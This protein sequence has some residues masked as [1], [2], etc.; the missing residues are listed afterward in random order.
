M[1][2][3]FGVIGRV[4]K[5]CKIKTVT[6]AKLIGALACTVDP[7]NEYAKHSTTVSR[8]LSCQQNLSGKGTP[9]DGS[10]SNRLSDIVNKA[11]EV[12]ANCVARDIARKVLPL[13]E[14]D[15]KQYIVPALYEIIARDKSISSNRRL[16]FQKYTTYSGKEIIKNEKVNLPTLLA[17]LLLYSIGVVKNKEG[18]SCVESI[19]AFFLSKAE[20]KYPELIVSYTFDMPEDLPGGGRLFIQTDVTDE[21]KIAIYQKRH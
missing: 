6:D 8:L 20:E 7:S 5:L 2:L 15:K 19:D 11:L 10:E 21:S 13:L 4:L 12:D 18:E 1:V 9:L 16:S 17:G 14:E 3:C